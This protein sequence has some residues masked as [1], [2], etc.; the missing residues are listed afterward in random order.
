MNEYL[1][2]LEYS[3]RYSLR[4]VTSN[5]ARSAAEFRARDNL[6]TPDAVHVAT[7]MDAGCDAFLT[8]D[9]ACKRV[10]DLRVLTLGQLTL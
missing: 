3:G 4:P 6:R 1:E 5:I 7:V 10:S 8:N 9:S 2:V